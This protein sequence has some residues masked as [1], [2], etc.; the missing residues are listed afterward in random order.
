MIKRITTAAHAASRVALGAGALT[1]LGLLW[2]L[3]ASASTLGGTATISNTSGTALTGTLG[4]AQAFTVTLPPNTDCSGD[5]QHGGYLVYSYLVPA[6]TSVS[7]LTFP[8]QQPG[9]GYGLFDSNGYYGAQNT[10]PTTGQITNVPLDFSWSAL[11]GA[12]GGGSALYNPS[13][14]AGTS[15]T[16]QAG[17]A[18]AVGTGAVTDYWVDNV[19]FTKSTTD[20]NGFTWTSSPGPGTQSP[21]VPMAIVLPLGG[22]ALLAGGVALTRRR[23]KQGQVAVQA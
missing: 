21:E 10:A 12:I 4:S 6:G 8:G 7:T 3:P 9:T 17:I 23:R 19:T 22:I 5:T 20:A 14:G 16:W 18:C 11:S 2:A 13:G 1:G 15:A